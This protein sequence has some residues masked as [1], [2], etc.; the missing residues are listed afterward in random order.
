[1]ASVKI[2]KL[3]EFGVGTYVDYSYYVMFGGG[4]RHC[5]GIVTRIQPRKK[6]IHWRILGS[7]EDTRPILYPPPDPQ[8]PSRWKFRVIEYDKI[9][10]CAKKNT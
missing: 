10:D 4:V 7:K 9:P 5:Y 8:E 1:M 3:G 2:A 6:L